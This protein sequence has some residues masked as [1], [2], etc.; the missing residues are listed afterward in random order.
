MGKQKNE[1]KLK[2]D[3]E[4]NVKDRAVNNA[5]TEVIELGPVGST[6]A[7]TG[8]QEEFVLPILPLR[9]TVVFPQTVV[10]LAAAQARSLRLIDEVMSGDRTVGVVMQ[11]DSEQEGAGPG[12]FTRSARSAPFSDDARARWQ[13]SPRHSRH[14]A[15]ADRR[16]GVR[17]AVSGRQGSPDARGSTD[18]VEV[19]A[20]SRNTLE[21]FQR[22]VEL[23]SHL[24]DELVTAALNV[25]DPQHLV[26]L[27][28]TNLRMEPE[29]RQKLLELDSVQEKLDQL[30]A[31]I[32]KE[33]DVLELGKK[34]QIEVQEELGKSQR[35]YYLREQL[36]AI[37][38][39]LGEERDRSRGQR[40]APEDRRVRYARRGGERGE[41]RARSPEQ[42]AAGCRRVW[43]DQDLSRLVDLDALE[44][45]HRGRDRH[46]PKRARCSMTITTA[47][48][49]S[50][51]AF[52]STWRCA[53]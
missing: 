52:L 33:L 46:R 36:K 41:T 23:V 20:L 1:K 30:N 19:Q 15:H 42:A 48:R 27:V 4:K 47:W 11:K 50:R 44:Q 2:K 17:R 7:P 28:A 26:Y 18:S 39:E 10:P 25:D 3:K 14:R 51:I 22:L 5:A 31:F 8:E 35:E 38:R 9:G 6:G 21:L 32:T 12:E 49:R 37:Q 29:E 24:P 16:M 34:L 45:E 53:S 40:A 43:R 13:R